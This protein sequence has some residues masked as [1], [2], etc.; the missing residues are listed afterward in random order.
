MRQT[1]MIG[2]T[3]TRLLFAAGLTAAMFISAAAGQQPAAGVA[4]TSPAPLAVTGPVKNTT[5]LKN[6]AHGYPF[7]ATPM[8]LKKAG[9]V[10]EEFFI[11]GTASRF[12][13]AGTANATVADSGHPYKT[14][15]VVRRPA[16]ASKFNGTAIV[17]WT[18]VSQGHDH[19]IDWLEAADHFMRAGYAW[20]GVSAQAVGVDALKQWSPARYG[21]LNVS[22]PA[23]GGVVAPGGGR[24]G[25]AP[26]GGGGPSDLANDIFTQAAMAVRGKS[27]TDVMGGLKAQRVIA[28]GH[29]QSCGRLATYFNSIHPL[30]PVFDAVMLHGCSA[31]QMRT[32]LTVKI[33]NM[34]S[35][36][37][38]ASAPPDSDK[39]RVWQVAGSSHLDAQDSRGLGQVGLK[40]G[41][42]MPV[43]GPDVLKPPTISGGGA[44]IGTYQGPSTAANDGC[45][46]PTFSRI[47]FH[48]V[49]AA[50]YDHLTK[51]VKDGT[52]PPAAP[53]FEVANNAIVRDSAGN[54]KGGIQLS[55]HAVPTAL[56]R[57][58]NTGG[59]VCGLLGWH[60]PF[61]DAQLAK[62][63]PFHAV[64][65]KAVKDVTEKN[66]KAGYIVKADAE[67][68]IKE[69]T[70]SNIGAKK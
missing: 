26:R 45:G 57:G 63:Y 11:E 8:D 3:G 28:T 62:L 39:L 13:A 18:N 47:P 41:G 53:R 66:L 34:L 4:S 17:E 48:Y 70:N 54:A 19:E 52:L 43:D 58:D 35:E 65:V 55:Q 64:Y 68:T 49:L 37:E 46:H 7:N 6:P 38:G 30:S 24:G 40:A 44:G 25:G 1:P 31:A 20:I 21:T 51:W 50:A 15:I 61:D 60:E 29:S 14:R 67:A 5:E 33:F 56:N 9:Y 36:S 27:T 42:A 23:A 16:T 22:V 32:D 10:E 59:Q 69:A 12:T 2:R